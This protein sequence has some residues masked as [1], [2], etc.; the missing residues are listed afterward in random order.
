[1][2]VNTLFLAL[3]LFLARQVV[4]DDENCEWFGEQTQESV[5]PS[6]RM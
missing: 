2:C 3:S 6:I 4:A 5:R 1:M